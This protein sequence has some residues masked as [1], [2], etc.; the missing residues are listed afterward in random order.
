VTIA[1]TGPASSISAAAS[2]TCAVVKGAAQCWGTN[3]FGQ[4]GTGNTSNSNKPAPVMRLAGVV[5][6]DGGDRHSCAVLADGTGHCWGSNQYGQLG[7]GV[8]LERTDPWRVALEC[9]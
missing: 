7:S 5:M 8:P 6:I 9:P 4:L 3:R 1:M 2:H